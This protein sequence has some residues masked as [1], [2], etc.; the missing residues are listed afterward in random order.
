MIMRIMMI[1]MMRPRMTDTCWCTMSKQICNF[2]FKKK[3]KKIE[4]QEKDMTTRHLL[5]FVIY[6]QGFFLFR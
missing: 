1:M 5:M 3:K 2:F 4:I 6:N